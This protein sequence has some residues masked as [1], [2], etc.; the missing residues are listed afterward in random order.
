M[1]VLSASIIRA[2]LVLP[3]LAGL[4]FARDSRS[5]QSYYRSSDGT[6][7]HGPTLE[8]SAAY[9]RVSAD[10]RDGTHSYSHHHQGTCSG[11]GGVADWR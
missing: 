8:N 1:S 11:H 10:C 4:A 9:G 7:V 3:L 2:F 5:S 6:T